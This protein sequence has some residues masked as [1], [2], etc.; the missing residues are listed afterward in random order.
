MNISGFKKTKPVLNVSEVSEAMTNQTKQWTNTHRRLWFLHEC[1]RV[2][3]LLE[4]VIYLFI[5]FVY[6]TWSNLVEEREQNGKG[7]TPTAA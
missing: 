4:N 2:S 7:E 6:C 5:Y 3:Q 1:I